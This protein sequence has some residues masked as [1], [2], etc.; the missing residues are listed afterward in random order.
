MVS[1][2]RMYIQMGVIGLLLAFIIYGGG[3]GFFMEHYFSNPIPELQYINGQPRLTLKPEAKQLRTMSLVKYF[4]SFNPRNYFSL[5]LSN[6]PR[7]PLK[8]PRLLNRNCVRF[9]SARKCREIHTG[10]LYLR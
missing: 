1:A 7:R 6:T 9:S 5:K 2:A 10:E 3:M 8:N 4:V